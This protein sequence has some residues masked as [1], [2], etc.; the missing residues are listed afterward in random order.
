[1]DSSLTQDQ[2]Y[3]FL[4]DTLFTK[5]QICSTQK[6]REAARQINLKAVLIIFLTL[7]LWG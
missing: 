5:M 3:L 2:F 4:F 7:L 1:M 6:I